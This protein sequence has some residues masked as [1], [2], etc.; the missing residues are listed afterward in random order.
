[1]KQT[2]HKASNAAKKLLLMLCLEGSRLFK[3]KNLNFSATI[4]CSQL[5]NSQVS[6]YM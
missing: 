1:M 2:E 6:N 4:V 5:E 3:N